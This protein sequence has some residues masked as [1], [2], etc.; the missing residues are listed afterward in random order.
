MDPWKPLACKPN[1]L[2]IMTLAMLVNM[3][4]HGWLDD[5]NSNLTRQGDAP[6]KIA[7]TH[8]TTNRIQQTW[9]GLDTLHQSWKNQ[10]KNGKTIGTGPHFVKNSSPIV[11]KTSS[12]LH[13]Q[14][15]LRTAETQPMIHHDQRAHPT[16]RTNLPNPTNATKTSSLRRG[17]KSLSCPGLM[18]GFC[19]SEG[20]EMHSWWY[21]NQIELSWC[22]CI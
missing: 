21:R 9:M 1:R 19:L 13:A 4:F 7:F 20:P 12:P 16:Y 15:L 11:K 17:S 2:W 8:L 14:E 10:R 5:D 18:E 22:I 6:H 3:Y